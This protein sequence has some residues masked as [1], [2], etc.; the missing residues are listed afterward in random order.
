MSDLQIGLVALGVVLILVVVIFNWWQ[1]R[2]I[3]RRMQAQFPPT[4]EDPLLGGL[5]PTVGR[6]EPALGAVESHATDADPVVPREA[7]TEEVDA[8]C[9]AVIDIAFPQ[10]VPGAELRDAARSLAVSDSKPVR[11]FA[12]TDTGLHR[13]GLPADESCVSMQ[14]AILLANRTG[15]LTDIEWSRLWTA[16][17]S[18][19]DRF[20]GSVEGPELDHVIER[21]AALD[22]QCAG[23][24][25]QVGLAVMLNGAQPVE[26][27]RNLVE[28]SGFVAVGRHLA[29]VA[30]SG[31]ARFTLLFD[32]V[33]VSLFQSASVSRLDLL[34][35][36]PNSPSD[37]QAFSRM[38]GVARDLCQRLG[39]QLVDDQGREVNPASDTKIDEQLAALYAEL[40]KAGFEPGTER[41]ARLFS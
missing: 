1:D 23:L 22:E 14:L 25:A 33:P 18:L 17:Q 12:E 40:E 20:E 27:V 29:W 10:P 5:P 16:A 32:G 39:G 4:D 36:L 6:R 7:D 26:Q 11:I 3:R 13:V 38:A 15:P 2:R 28:D 19:A 34:L 8:V 37:R 21:A 24:D 41:T 9:E 31:L 35:D 30:E